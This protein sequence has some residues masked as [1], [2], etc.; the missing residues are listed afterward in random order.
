[1]KRIRNANEEMAR[2]IEYEQEG[3]IWVRGC[4][5]FTRKYRGSSN[6]ICSV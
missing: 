3:R 2:I 5:A 4:S 1:L 6:K